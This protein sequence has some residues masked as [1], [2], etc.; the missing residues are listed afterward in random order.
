[1]HPSDVQAH[2]DRLN[3]GLRVIEF[4]QSTATAQAAADAAG[5]ELGAI[6]KSLLFLVDGQPV[7]VLISG[8]QTGDQR[9]LG[10]LFGVGR[11]KVRIA[12][13]ETVRVVT[14]YDVGGVPPVAHATPLPVVID[15]MLGRYETVW[16]AAGAHNA[17]FPIAYQTLIDI[18]HGQVA[19]IVKTKAEITVD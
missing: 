6:V 18:T 11:K 17:V 1:M 8:D 3:L 5:C 14:G 4:P 2:L 12:D 10:A 19:D 15:Q 9:K 7:M 16:A 13:A